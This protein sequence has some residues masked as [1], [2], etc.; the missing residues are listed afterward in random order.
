MPY[1]RVTHGEGDQTV[2]KAQSRAQTEITLIGL[3]EASSPPEL[4]DSDSLLNLS[5]LRFLNY[6]VDKGCT[7]VYNEE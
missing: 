6:G 4:C 2:E 5:V 7:L 1:H 3:N